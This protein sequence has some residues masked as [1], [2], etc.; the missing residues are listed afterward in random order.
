MPENSGENPNE[1]GMSG[2]APNAR[3]GEAVDMDQGPEQDQGRSKDVYDDLLDDPGFRPQVKQAIAQFAQQGYQGG[4]PQQEQPKD[5]IQQLEEQ[6]AEKDRYIEEFFS[7]PDEE[8]DYAEYERT[9]NE[10][11]RLDRQLNQMRHQRSQQQVA[12]SRS[13]EVINRWIK[14]KAEQERRQFGEPEI[15]NYANRVREIAKGLRPEVL[16]NENKLRETL[17]YSIEPFAFKEF[18]RSQRQGG[19]RRPVREGAGRD[20][21][22]DEGGDGPHEDGAQDKFAD[23]SEEEREFL[24]GVGLIGGEKKQEPDLVPV[25]GGYQIP[26]RPGRRNQAGGES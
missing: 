18:Q 8:R 9:K 12:L 3:E 17:E 5:P 6:I 2:E 7:K 16:A 26:I 14:S 13:D 20:D 1:S 21:Y 11:Q 15:N 23:A 24:K 4:Q 25:K 10:L 22:T 19:Q